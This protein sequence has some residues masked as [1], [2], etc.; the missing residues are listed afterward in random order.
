VA[1]IIQLS[2]LIT[3][4]LRLSLLCANIVLLY[5]CL[6]YI[7]KFFPAGFQRGHRPMGSGPSD[8]GLIGTGG[9][10]AALVSDLR[11]SLEVAGSSRG[12]T[13]DLRRHTALESLGKPQWGFVTG[14]IPETGVGW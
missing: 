11:N 7:Y 5:H 3:S 13:R 6:C 14:L 1:S 10:P 9:G 4:R 8:G 12:E 2:V